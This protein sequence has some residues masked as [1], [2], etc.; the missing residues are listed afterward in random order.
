M[1]VLVNYELKPEIVQSLLVDC[2]EGG[3]SGWIRKAE[4]VT[5]NYDPD[6]NL[7]WYGQDA[8]VGVGDNTINNFKFKLT[9][10][11]EDENEGEGKTTKMMTPYQVAHGLAILSQA[12]PS[13]FTRI[14]TQEGDALDA[15]AFM[16]CCVFGKIVYG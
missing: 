6:A 9:Y 3:Y 2:F 11:G 14:I 15:D 10:D 5:G 8:F 12:N 16:Q 4:R 7:V 1:K 13:V